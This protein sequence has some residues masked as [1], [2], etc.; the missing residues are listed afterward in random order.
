MGRI[1]RSDFAFKKEEEQKQLSELEGK[2]IFAAGYCRLSVDNDESMSLENQRAVIEKCLEDYPNIKLKKFFEDDGV[3]GTTMDRPGWT[4]MMQEVYQGKIQCIIV[5]DLSRF[6]RNYVETGY[7]LEHI[8]PKMGVRFIACTE[9]LD[10]ETMP[11]MVPIKIKNMVND[12][13]ARDISK[14]V[15]AVFAKQRE[16]GELIRTPAYGYLLNDRELVPDPK[17][18]PLVKMMF[19]W[20]EL[21][22]GVTQIADRLTLMGVN[23]P[24]EEGDELLPGDETIPWYPT[25]VKRILMNETMVG[26]F[27]SGKTLQRMHKRTSFDESDWTVIEEHHEGIISPEQFAAVQAQLEKN[28]VS[29]ECN[30]AYLKE[31]DG[32]IFCGVCGQRMMAKARCNDRKYTTYRCFNHTGVVRSRRNYTSLETAP[33]IKETVLLDRIE[34]QA[35][36]LKP[37]ETKLRKLVQGAQDLG[38]LLEKPREALIHAKQEKEAALKERD[39]VMTAHA[40]GELDT[41]TYM[42]ARG[43]LTEKCEKAEAKME[44]QMVKLQQMERD[45]E[46]TK[47]ALRDSGGPLEKVERIEVFPDGTVQIRFK[48]EEA[49]GCIERWLK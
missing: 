16:R 30:P 7:Y 38:G 42:L 6:G 26:T 25:T 49:L 2:F 32:K 45:I 8:F 37:A 41:Q 10:T 1:R 44:K 14:K 27:V 39:D 23:P 43:L 29:R 15:S 31:L 12:C 22:E 11:D 21:G 40:N 4:Q 19:T 28:T 34:E 48:V 35:E 47:E 20:A 33:I 13:Y 46:R 24:K 3:T 18:A 17:T 9:E 5:K 36:K